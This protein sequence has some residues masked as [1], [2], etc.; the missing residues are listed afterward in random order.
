MENVLT[1]DDT[2][3]GICEA[4]GEDFGFNANWLRLALGVGLLLNPMAS[5]A[6]YACAGI[7]V[8]ATRLIAP[9]PRRAVEP[10]ETNEAEA[11]EPEQPELAYEAPPLAA[12]A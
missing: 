12:A 4:I 2:F 11:A 9:N 8:G 3:L 5:I 1:R 6:A 7:V 10:A